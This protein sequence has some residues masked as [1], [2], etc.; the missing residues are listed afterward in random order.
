MDALEAILT[1]RSTRKFSK[2]MPDSALIDA[3]SEVDGLRYAGCFDA[4]EKG[5]EAA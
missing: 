2:T 5:N 3:L 1:R 4:A